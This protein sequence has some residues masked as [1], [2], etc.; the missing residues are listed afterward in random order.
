MIARRPAGRLAPVLVLLA[1]AGLLIAGYLLAVRLA[2][3][4]P[5]CPISGGCETV[6]SSE[7]S[8]IAGVPVAGVGV[9]YSIVLVVATV[10]WWRLGDRR[11][12]YVAYGLGLLGT[13]MVGYLTYLELFVIRA[14][15]TWCVAYG[16]TV[17]LG[18]LGAIASL[19]S[20]PAN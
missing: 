3:E 17:V 10:G 16:L 13:L 6:Q 14:V 1:I 7:Y 19:R 18:W 4:L 11:A 12:L 20:A 2:G 9:A 15:C 8:A 5:A